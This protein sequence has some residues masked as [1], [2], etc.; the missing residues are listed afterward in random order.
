ML[1]VQR[2]ILSVHETVAR[3]F[4]KERRV[5]QCTYGQACAVARKGCPFS[6]PFIDAFGA[7]IGNKKGQGEC[8]AEAKLRR[9]RGVQF[10]RVR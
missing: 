7:S 5:F 4:Q 9:L 1:R 10:A 2:H 8:P 3:L 6:L